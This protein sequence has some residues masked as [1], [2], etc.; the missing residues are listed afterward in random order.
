MCGVY[1]EGQDRRK[2]LHRRG[3]IEVSGNPLAVEGSNNFC[4]PPTQQQ[5]TPCCVA[6]ASQGPSLCQRLQQTAQVS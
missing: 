6:L 5:Q 2:A 3:A 1:S 4:K